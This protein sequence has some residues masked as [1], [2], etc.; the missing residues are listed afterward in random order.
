VCMCCVSLASG[1]RRGDLCASTL[2]K[3]SEFE[4]ETCVL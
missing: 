3:L 2:L 1:A 4:K